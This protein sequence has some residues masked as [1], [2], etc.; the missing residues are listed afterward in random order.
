MS[1]ETRIKEELAWLKVIFA[2]II[3]IS[4][5]ILAWLAQNYEVTTKAILVASF[6]VFILSIYLLVRITKVVYEKLDD[7]ERF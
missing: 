7:L 6:V 4:V 5:S 3:T 2:I 1:K